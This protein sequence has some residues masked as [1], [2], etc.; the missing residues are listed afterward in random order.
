MNAFLSENHTVKVTPLTVAI[1]RSLFSSNSLAHN[2]AK[3]VKE[4]F[5]FVL[6]FSFFLVSCT[7]LNLI[8]IS[9]CFCLLLFWLVP[10]PVS[11]Y[12]LHLIVNFRIITTDSLDNL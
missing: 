1:R 10:V 4:S 5:L 9:S 12:M 7:S 8:F 11:L 6:M 2:P 3:P